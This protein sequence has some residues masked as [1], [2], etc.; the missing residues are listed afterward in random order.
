MLK[1][2]KDYKKLKFSEPTAVTIGVFDGVHK[3]HA[4]IF[5]KTAEL[6]RKLNAR[7]VAVTFNFSKKKV[8]TTL[9]EKYELMQNF[10]IDTAVRLE[11][12]DDWMEWSPLEFI[13]RFLIGRLNASAVIVGKDFKFGNERRGNIRTLEESSFEVSSLNLLKYGE[14]KISSTYIRKTIIR[15]EMEKARQMLG[16]P[17]SFRGK[18]VKGRGAGSKMGFPTINFNVPPEKLLPEGVFETDITLLAGEKK[19]KKRA[20]CFIG[21]VG[22]K[23]IEK[24]YRTVEVHI[25]DYEVDI[26]QK[27]LKVE[28]K[29]F[30]RRPINFSRREDLIRQIK[31][32]LDT[33]R[34]DI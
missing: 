30:I 16:R 10:N 9:S 13:E 22:V 29:R 18:C 23:E 25:P 11:G 17:Y 31:K 27:P 8:L 7:P 26:G 15:G 3:G 34:H 6:A 2:Y 33:V 14:H 28:F 20:A 24:K 32:D 21:P 4:R 19:T 12:G 5:S 1:I